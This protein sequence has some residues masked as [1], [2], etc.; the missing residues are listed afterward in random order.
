MAEQELHKNKE[1]S[2]AS[3]PLQTDKLQNVDYT[4]D[5]SVDFRGKPAIRDKSGGLRTLPF[6]LGVQ[7]FATIAYYGFGTNLVLYLTGKL[8]ENV[9]TAST[10]VTNWNGAG[11]LFSVLGA[12][13]A[14]S[15]FG[16]FWTSVAFLAVYFVGLLLST[17]TTA[18]PSLKPLPCPSTST[19]C[20]PI[21]GTRKS[22]FFLSMYIQALGIGA[23]QPCNVSFGADQFDEQHEI[24]RPQKSL[25]FN[26]VYVASSMGGL[27]G[28][29]FLIYL[30]QHVS[31]I[32]GYGAST[33]LLGFSLVIYVSGITL[34]RH[35][36]VKGNPLTRMGKVLVATFRK[37]RLKSP[38]DATQLY[39]ESSQGS[40]NR[41]LLHSDKFR[42]LDKAA[43][44]IEGDIDEHGIRKSWRL[45]TVT[46]VEEVKFIIRL[47]PIWASNVYYSTL[48]VQILTL[49]VEQ[50]STMNL[51][52]GN[53]N[54]PPASIGVFETLS[55]C[56][57]AFAYEK[58]IVPL[59]RRYTGN[60]RGITLLQ[61]MGAGLVIVTF[62]MVV[63][64]AVEIKRLHVIKQHG[65]ADQPYATVPMSVFW[66]IPQYF[67][68]GC[69]E[70]FAYIG[71]YEFFYDQAP[72]EIRGVSSGL[73]YTT[74]A[75]GNFLSSLLVTIV[76]RVTKHGNNPG[77]IADNLNAAH[78]DYFYW[79]LV[80][81][82]VV[83]FIV[84]LICASW[85]EYTNAAY[86]ENEDE[87][88]AT[89]NKF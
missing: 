59:T 17:L 22:I 56:F 72:D 53:F 86:A 57:W 24:E 32:W 9:S 21:T 11:L 14:D 43:V 7:F 49:F 35:Q 65:L 58:W 36:K 66:L 38:S 15:Y 84:Y 78:I 70:T 52:I 81:L 28:N 55:V 54:I 61:R 34:F 37:W 40:N 87:E 88:E 76:T 12:F 8:R 27:I 63:A 74:L 23:F 85:Y 31:Y 4:K 44:K 75:L 26:L 62:A 67:L 69:S 20:P 42:F 45:C 46:Q 33:L 68:V 30:E 71:Q 73:Q 5:G 83:N 18:L 25:F 1:S 10:A 3:Q 82:G 50:A 39:E 6:V 80:V 60:P 47:L 51:H 19:S 48:Y 89:D 41:Q 29:T 16:R 13:L 2:F 64:A 79:L 77:W